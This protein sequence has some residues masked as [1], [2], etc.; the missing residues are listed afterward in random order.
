VVRRKLCIKAQFLGE[1]HPNLPSVP[2]IVEFAQSP[3]EKQLFQLFANDGEIGKAILAPA[4]APPSVV[5]IL[6]RAFDTMTR[7][8][9]YIA[10]ADKLQLS[11]IPH[12][13]KN[14]KS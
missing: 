3:A 1:R 9:E 4:G 10:D 7:D 14:C 6:R 5:T 8:P 2:T 13:A 12:P 11:A